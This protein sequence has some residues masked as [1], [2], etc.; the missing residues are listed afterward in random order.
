M[1]PAAAEG[2]MA[3]RHRIGC[4]Q[5]LSRCE[6][7]VKASGITASRHQDLAYW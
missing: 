4:L 3:A 1:R 5:K 2:A 6:G 7:P